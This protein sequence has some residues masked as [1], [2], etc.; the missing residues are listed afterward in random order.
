[1]PEEKNIAVI[2]KPQSTEQSKSVFDFKDNLKE[3]KQLGIESTH[4]DFSE[5]YKFWLT[6]VE[7]ES[8]PAK[9]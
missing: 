6:L 4:P 5:H 9:E 3:L 2:K 8:L 1:M 7:S